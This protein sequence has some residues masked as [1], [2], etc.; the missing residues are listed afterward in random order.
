MRRVHLKPLAIA[1][2]LSLSA[3]AAHAADIEAQLAPGDGFEVNSQN[4]TVVRLRVNDDGSVVVPALPGT[5][6]EEQFLCFDTASG[7]LGRC[8]IP[9]AGPTGATGAAGATG[10]IGPAGSTGAAGAT[11]AT[12]LIGP[13]GAT[14]SAGATGATGAAGATG[15]IGATGA[16]GLIGPAGATGTAGATGATGAAGDTGAIGPAGVPGATGAT[17]AAGATGAT[18]ATGTGSSVTGVAVNASGTVA[19]TDTIGTQTSTGR[20]WRV[21]GN[22]GTAVANDYVGTSDATDFVTRTNGTEVM[23][24]TTNQRVGIGTPIPATKLDVLSGTGDAIYGH[25]NNV[26]AYL[27][28]ETNFSFG[29]PA[30]NMN[31]AGVYASNAFAGY[32]SMFAQSTGNATVAAAINYSN[33]W[34]ANYNLVDNSSPTLSPNASFSQLNVTNAGL[35]G[36]QSAVRGSSNRGTTAGNPGYSVGVEGIANAQ[37]Q[38]S[39]GVVGTAYSNSTI[40]AG[41]YFEGLTYPGAS[42]AYAYVGGTIDGATNRKIVGTGSVSEII[43]TRAHGRVTM[44]APESPEYW[45][46]DYGSVQMVDGY[47]KVTLDPIL[48][49]IIVVDAQNPVRVFATPVGM[50]EFN[51]V[52]VMNQTSNSFELVELNR[53]RHSGRIDYQIVAKPKTNYGEG[54]FP[55]APGPQGLKRADEPAAA[56]AANQPDPAKIF[57]WPADHVQYNYDPAK[58]RSDRNGQPATRPGSEPEAQD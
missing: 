19:V 55:Q 50:P 41:G 46:Q 26:G 10:A 17:G 18:G 45:Y 11:G 57:R 51:G 20:L 22:S 4:G 35:G 39:I 6:G 23:R 29:S 14:G 32:P 5:A 30:Q 7:Q 36:A 49:D 3:A 34:I 40:S 25:S 16:T 15:A 21:G 43:P 12:G 24:A 54:R 1:I 56:K 38:D 27:G 2:Q 42:R 44:T 48:V 53:G 47:A 13:A 37:N 52:T 28:Y 58:L 31:G 33:V 8:L 9:P